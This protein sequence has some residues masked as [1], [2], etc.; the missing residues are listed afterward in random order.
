M[1]ILLVMVAHW[2]ILESSKSADCNKLHFEPHIYL[3][4]SSY[5]AAVRLVEVTALSSQSQMA[6]GPSHI[7]PFLIHLDWAAQPSLL[8]TLCVC[9]RQ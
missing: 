4:A 3:I 7:N 8:H 1:T 5:Y 6:T 9:A 2:H